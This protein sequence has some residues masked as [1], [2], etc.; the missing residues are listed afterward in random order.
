MADEPLIPLNNS[1]ME[2]WEEKSDAELQ[3]IVRNN[4]IGS[5]NYICAR[6]ELDRRE[7]KKAQR[8]QLRWI[9]LTFWTALALGVAGTVATLLRP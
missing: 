2:Y 5:K 1:N 9:K 7:A 4:M 6:D 8:Q 3:E